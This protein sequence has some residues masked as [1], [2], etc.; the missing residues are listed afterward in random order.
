MSAQ[1]LGLW[2]RLCLAALIAVAS[3]AASV[4]PVV[5]EAVVALRSD[6]H[7]YRMVGDIDVGKLLCLVVGCFGFVILMLPDV[8]ACS[9][10]GCPGM[11]WR[12]WRCLAWSLFALWF[13]FAFL[14][15]A[16]RTIQCLWQ[17]SESVSSNPISTVNLQ[18]NFAVAYVSNLA[19][20]LCVFLP[21]WVFAFRGREE[22][23]FYG[24]K[25]VFASVALG[26]LNVTLLIAS[27]TA[28]F[29]AAW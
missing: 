16:W 29:R 23:T 13:Q 20:P 7:Y 2:R 17:L 12:P 10:S 19:L 1:L 14:S 28:V 26:F 24:Q 6:G 15:I 27:L 3:G 8:A 18:S 11:Q 22:I 9:V 4:V 5:I 25:W 21:F